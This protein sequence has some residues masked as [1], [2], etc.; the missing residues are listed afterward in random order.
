MTDTD[1]N[2]RA[3]P[4]PRDYL[5]EKIH[6]LMDQWEKEHGE[7]PTAEQM[8][9]AVGVEKSKTPVMESLMEGKE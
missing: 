2:L 1:L 5:R 7:R 8:I 3:E 4:A 9:E 6:E